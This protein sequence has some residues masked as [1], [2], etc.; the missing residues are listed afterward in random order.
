MK[1]AIAWIILLMGAGFL[2]I[3][4]V[5]PLIVGGYHLIIGTGPFCM[6]TQTFIK[7]FGYSIL[8][9]IALF[10]PIITLYAIWRWTWA[11]ATGE[12]L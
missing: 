1:K 3:Y 2:G 10:G 8:F 9:L 11:K 12:T 5:F 7:I 6:L 4:V